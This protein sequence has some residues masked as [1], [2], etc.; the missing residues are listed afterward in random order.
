MDYNTQQ[1][2]LPLPVYGRNVQRMVDYLLTIDDREKRTEQAKLVIKVMESITAH[3]RDVKDYEQKLWDHLHIMANYQLDVDMDFE[4]PDPASLHPVPDR[5]EYPQKS[6]KL[7]HYGLYV[8]KMIEDIVE[9][10]PADKVNT[11]ALPIAKRMRRIHMEWKKEGVSDEE[12]IRDLYALSQGKIQLVLGQGETLSE[13]RGGDNRKGN[14][15]RSSSSQQ[16]QRNNR[17][18]RKKR[19][20]S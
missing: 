13:G 19:K 1:Q 3:L 5:L 15:S 10:A 4:K 11:L 6:K 7:N 9:N 2:S 12:I 16:N 8:R 14:D 20:S 18:K 17:K